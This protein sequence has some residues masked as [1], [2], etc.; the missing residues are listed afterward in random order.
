VHGKVF[1]PLASSCLTA[2]LE[3]GHEGI[4]KTLHRFRVDF[5]IHGARGLVK[6]FVRNCATCQR[7]K[8]EHLHP[9]GLLQLLDV[10]SSIWADVAMGFVEGFP[11]VNGKTVVP[12]VVDHFSKYAHFVP[13]AH[14]YTATTV[15]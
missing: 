3:V 9:A 7:Y 15:A 5:F 1:I 10:P 12:T 2:A 13:L 11:R 14:P 8:G 6:E 4:Q